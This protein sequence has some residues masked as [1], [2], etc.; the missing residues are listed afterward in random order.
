[1]TA[2][3]FTTLP[4]RGILALSGPDTIEFLQNLI[5]NDVE[6]VGPDTSVYSLLLTAQGKLLHDFFVARLG[7]GTLVPGLRG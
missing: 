2:L 5:S 6:R 1:M 7:D 3:T 4:R